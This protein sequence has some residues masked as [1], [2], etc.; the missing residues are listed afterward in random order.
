MEFLMIRLLCV[1]MLLTTPAFSAEVIL[2]QFDNLTAPGAT[3]EYVLATPAGT[4][5]ILQSVLTTYYSTLFALTSHA[6]SGV[7]L[8]SESQTLSFANSN[9]TISGGNS[10][11]LSS[12]S[13]SGG[14]TDHAELTNLDYASAGHTGFAPSLGVDDNYVTDAEKAAL[15]PIVDISGKQDVLVGSETIFDGWDKNAT[16]DF[17]GAYTSLSA[18]PATFAPSSH[19]NSAHS[20]TYLTA[21]VDGSITNEIELTA[22]ELAA[23]QGAALPSA[24]NVL[25]TMND[26]AEAGGGDITG[27]TAGTGLSG[28]GL[29]GDVTLNLADTAVTPGAYTNADV[30][31]DQQGRVTAVAS[32]AGGGTDDQT[33]TE[34][35]YSNT[36]SG[37]IATDTQAAV[38]EVEGRVDTA[39][40]KLAGIESGATA[41]QTGAEIKLAYES[42]LDTNAYTDAEK[43]KL[44]GIAA[45]AEINVNADWTAISGDAQILNKPTLGTAADNAETDFAA[46]L[47]A[48]DNYVTDDQK[49]AFPLGAAAL[50]PLILDSDARLTDSRAPNSHNNTAHSETYLT[51]EVDGSVTNEIQD[52]SLAGNTLSLSGDGTT[53]DLS[54]YMDNTDAQTLSFAS[55]NLSITGGNS[56]DISAIQD[57][58]GTDDQTA[59]EVP[60]TDTGTYF[61]GTDVESALQE[62]GPTMTDARTPTLHAATHGAGQTDAVTITE[63]QISDL[64]HTV[65]TDNQTALDVATTTTGFAGLLSGTDT[66]V[67][68]ALDTLDD[69]VPAWTDITSIP[70]GFAD[71]IDNTGLPTQII[72]YSDYASFADFDTACVEGVLAYADVDDT[73]TGETAT[74]E[75]PVQFLP[76]VVWTDS[77]TNDITF[78]GGL[79]SPEQ[80]ILSGFS[81]GEI[82]LP[83]GST[84][85]VYAQWFGLVSGD[86]L[87]DQTAMATLLGALVSNQAVLMPEGGVFNTTANLTLSKS[88]IVFDGRGATVVTDGDSGF[89]TVTPTQKDSDT[90]LSI[91]ITAQD[92]SFTIPA[93]VTVAEGDLIN[94]YSDTDWSTSYNYHHGITATVMEIDG[95]TGY[96]DR[97]PVFSFTAHNA[98]VYD[99]LE[100]TKVKNFIIDMTAHD[101]DSSGNHGIYMSFVNNGKMLNNRVYGNYQYSAIAY[102]YHGTGGEIRNNHGQ[103][104]FASQNTSPTGYCVSVSGSGTT[105][106]D[107]T[108]VN[109]RH[110]LTSAYRDNDTY[111]LNFGGNILYTEDRWAGTIPS[112]VNAGNNY[113]LAAIDMHSSVYDGA[114]RENFILTVNDAMVTYGGTFLTLQNNHIQ[115]RDAGQTNSY[116][117]LE[118]RTDAVSQPVV[119]LN[120]NYLKTELAGKQLQTATYQKYIHNTS[121][122]DFSG[123]ALNKPTCDSYTKGRTWYT[124][125]TASVYEVCKQT[126]ASTYSWT[127]F[128]LPAGTF[129]QMLVHDGSSFKSQTLGTGGDVEFGT[130]YNLDI[131]ADSIKTSMLDSADTPTDGEC[132]TAMADGTFNFDSCSG[133]AQPAS[134]VSVTTTNFNGNFAN[135][136]SHDSAQ[137]L[138]DLIDDF[139][140]SGLAQTDIDTLAELNTVVTDATLIGSSGTPVTGQV[141]YWTDASTVAGSDAFTFDEPA[142]GITLTSSTTDATRGLTVKQ[143]SDAATAASINF[144]KDRAGG[145]TQSG[146]SI[147]AFHGYGHDGTDPQSGASLFYKQDGAAS[148]GAV[149]MGITLATGSSFASRGNRMV[150]G[151]NG[152]I[153]LPDLAST[154]T[155]GSAYVCVYDSGVIYASETACP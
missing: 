52:L 30:T 100:N 139:S 153:T 79:L 42:E 115:Q 37:L 143:T 98:V 103:D 146:D 151:S 91:A 16:D 61:I 90:G 7:Y 46:A 47:G 102:G 113:S 148:A 49:A 114:F 63:A 141:T 10:V 152:T 18:I 101:T 136:T 125:Q 154:Y 82:T 74:L 83:G 4:R 87:S 50:D 93:G 45:G 88:G 38:D 124:D 89:L 70:A 145:A 35:P 109:F 155:G 106:D 34:V 127:A 73:I 66:D 116:D 95:T 23:V 112:G 11:D 130:G 119:Y 123:I 65:N 77:G 15:H 39:E 31:V 9:L 59:A 43:T 133:A 75:C 135:D 129:K 13:A 19:N 5:N 97:A 150:I 149:P 60:I 110:H 132:V 117:F 36:A 71:G 131:Q 96:L 32:G 33:A 128:G 99:I 26:I 41:D 147:G 104:M 111:G 72:L 140:L 105:I 118:E 12:L 8:E 134:N 64:T 54:G 121:S 51:T 85:L 27:V 56:V 122:N 25:A 58:T 80:T 69:Y 14:A 3:D 108:C 48:D 6:H 62:V 2:N 78:T 29:T 142:G 21:E 84:P 126:A 138:F 86:S 68:K 92:N 20:E 94:L 144:F 44:D 107:N 55:P 40:T 22:D 67:Q 57:G 120:S 76:G 1:L 24:T 17:D 53:V 137:E 28:G 81:A